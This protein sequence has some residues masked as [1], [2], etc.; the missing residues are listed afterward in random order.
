V[1]STIVQRM[2]LFSGAA[3]L[4]GVILAFFVECCVFLRLIVIVLIVL[5]MSLVVLAYLFDKVFE[6][7]NPIIAFGFYERYFLA[8][9]TGVLVGSFFAYISKEYALTIIS[10]ISGTILTG[11]G[12]FFYAKKATFENDVKDVERK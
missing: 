5:S 4:T 10:L 2:R 7:S 1:K 3:L 11:L 6:G 9:G 12:A 8:V